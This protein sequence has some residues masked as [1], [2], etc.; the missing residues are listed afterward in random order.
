M[1][2]LVEVR[3]DGDV[4]VDGGVCGEE[5]LGG[6]AGLEP[7]HLAFS[8]SNGEMRILCPIALSQAAGMM[9]VDESQLSQH[10]FDI[11]KRQREPELQPHRE[12]DNLRV[13]S[14]PPEGE[15]LDHRTPETACKP[16]PAEQG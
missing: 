15:F 3:P 2:T 13:E 12:P 7:L 16:G 4:I 6:G 11:A 10:F 14:V 9:D 1:G 5:T 8:S